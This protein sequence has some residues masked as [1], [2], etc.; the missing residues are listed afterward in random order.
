MFYR[1]DTKV[2]PLRIQ[3]QNIYTKASNNL[4]VAVNKSWYQSTNIFHMRTSLQ[5]NEIQKQPSRGV[6]RKRCSENMEQIYRRTPLPKCYTHR[7]ER[8]LVNFLNVFRTPFLRTSLDGC[9]YRYLSGTICR[10]IH[11]DT[12]F[13][14]TNFTL[15]KTLFKQ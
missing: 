11:P 3:F 8:S 4:Q 10:V 6:L 9:F 15:S 1:N 13:S 5:A 14:N 7:H 12:F 2:S